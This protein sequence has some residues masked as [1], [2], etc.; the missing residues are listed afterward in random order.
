M[1]FDYE[2]MA[3]GK[4]G[5]QGTITA[6]PIAPIKNR[7]LVTNMHFREQTTKGGIAIIQVMMEKLEAFIPLG[8]SASQKVLTTMIHMR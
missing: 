5:V 6:D 7:V 3:K 1:D 8:T 4:K 2:A